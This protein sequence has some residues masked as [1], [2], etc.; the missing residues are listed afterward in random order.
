MTSMYV[1]CVQSLIRNFC[2]ARSSGKTTSLTAWAT[3]LWILST[4]STVA[5]AYCTLY[6]YSWQLDFPGG[7]ILY[8]DSIQGQPVPALSYATYLLTMWVADAMMLWRLVVFYTDVN[9]LARGLILS[10]MSLLYIGSLGTGCFT[11]MLSSFNQTLYS[12]LSRK[13][14]IPCFTLSVTL[15][16]FA[17]A[18]IAIR[19]LMYKR[20][21]EQ[22]LGK[23]QARKSPYTSIATMLIESSALYA[24]WSLV[25]IVLYALSD[26]GQYIMIQMLRNVQ[27]IAPLLIVYRVSKGTAWGETTSTNLNSTLTEPVYYDNQGGSVIM[28]RSEQQVSLESSDSSQANSECKGESV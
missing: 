5:D 27:V 10:F 25:F 7:P 2:S 4:I 22:S 20:F 9:A 15:N 6:A 26:P 1:V 11:I 17:T 24:T 13:V 18:F 16:V 21:T 23:K 12:T 3:I 28:H 8:L 14:A 19:L